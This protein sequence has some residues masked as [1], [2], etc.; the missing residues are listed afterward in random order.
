MI[1]V[2][3][4]A[5]DDNEQKDWRNELEKGLTG[6]TSSHSFWNPG[7]IIVKKFP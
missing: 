5:G 3:P 1:W 4:E 7:E 2:G 6:G